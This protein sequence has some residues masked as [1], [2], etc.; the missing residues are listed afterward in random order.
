M[1]EACQHTQEAGPATPIMM[2]KSL[3]IKRYLICK[4]NTSWTILTFFIISVGT[5]LQELHT[6]ELS[7]LL[8]MPLSAVLAWVSSSCSL[9]TSGPPPLTEAKPSATNASFMFSPVTSETQITLAYNSSDK[10]IRWRDN[11]KHWNTTWDNVMKN[12]GFQWFLEDERLLSPI[13]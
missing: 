4:K 11:C 9:A 2:M 3:H 1:E 12:W 7:S 6:A 8:Q 10:P 13:Y 5:K